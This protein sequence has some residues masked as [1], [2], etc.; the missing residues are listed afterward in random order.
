MNNTDS[1]RDSALALIISRPLTALAATA[2]MQVTLIYTWG[3]TGFGKL[4]GGGVPEWFST[5]FGKTFLAK[6][7]GL[8]VSFYSIALL[9]ALTA[10]VA[11]AALLTGEALPRK[12]KPLTR[13][14]IVLSMALFAQ[15]GFGKRL[16]ADHDGAHDLFV[17]MGVSLV[18]LL[19][20][21]YFDMLRTQTKRG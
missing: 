13:L 4:F 20:V 3:L 19:A 1:P 2:L 11:A 9:E 8:T 14:A 15:L 5:S 6:F 16:I 21:E 7:P 18:M 10:V 17:Y 12:A